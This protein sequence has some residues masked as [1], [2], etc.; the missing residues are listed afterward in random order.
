MSNSRP[1]RSRRPSK[2]NPPEAYRFKPG[3]SGNLKGRPKKSLPA[4]K[5]NPLEQ[6]FQDALIAESQRLIT[7]TEGGKQFTI[8]G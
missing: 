2:G 5:L 3:Q 6:A 4:G 1:P 8:S 7:V